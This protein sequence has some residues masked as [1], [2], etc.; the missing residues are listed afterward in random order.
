MSNLNNFLFQ[1]FIQDFLLFHAL[2]RHE[3][4][5]I[6]IPNVLQFK[7]MHGGKDMKL[8]FSYLEV[9]VIISKRNLTVIR[10]QELL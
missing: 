6:I 3:L 5:S 10:L 7:K 8:V 9:I 1:K 2:K 4:K